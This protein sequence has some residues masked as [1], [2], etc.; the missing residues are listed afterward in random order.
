MS[1]L[2]RAVG[3]SAV[4][5]V[6]QLITWTA[7]LLLTAALGRY[8]GDAGFG[9]LYLAIS[10]GAIFSVL[11]EFGL[12][13]QLVRAVARDR[14]LAGTYLVNSV[15]I[16]LVLSGVAYL[17][18]LAL[19]EILGYSADLRLTILV[20]CVILFFN[21]LSAS[22]TGVY[23]ASERV[24]H[25]A[26]ATILEK[27]SVAA[28]AML[29]L[30]A[31]YGVTAVAAVLVLGAAIGVLWKALLLRKVVQISWSLSLQTMRKLALGALPFF[32]YWALGS[33]YYRVDV[34]LLSK[35]TD[36][37]TVGWYG[38]AYRLFDTLVFLPSLISSAIMFP[39]LSRLAEVSRADLRLAMGKGLDVIVILGVPICTGLYVLAEPIIQ[40]IYGKPEFLPAVPALRLLALGLFMLYVNSVLAIAL[41]SLNQ[42]RKMTVVA[43]LATVMN[44]GLNWLLIPHFQHVAAAGV[45]V[46]T[47]LLIFGCLLA[48]TPKDLV[49]WHNLVV[50]LKA[51]ASGAVMTVTLTLLAGQSILVLVP[52][53][54]LTY[55][56]SAAALR[57]VPADDI[58]V[59]GQALAARRR[60]RAVP[61]AT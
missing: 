36:A 7:T 25:S 23:Q 15:A 51:A 10:F 43:A 60:A 6:S 48:F 30:L 22:L 3:N 9:N 54:G 42:E 4:M 53:G 40:F 20:Y 34:V 39:I 13:Q 28:L 44:L 49:A 37:A 56:V 5:L 18:I 47:E 55:C 12:D 8:L 27:I 35:L 45:T 58:R 32:L 59:F 46:L 26:V 61:V 52:V 11:V 21:G 24:F 31:G 57:L 16:K 38:A 17:G 1:T 33:V 50:F 29:F 2:E 41:V 14:S 19:V